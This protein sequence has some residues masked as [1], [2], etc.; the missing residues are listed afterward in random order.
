MKPEL[1][2][3]LCLI[4]FCV[5]VLI[6]CLAKKSNA[7]I[8]ISKD[9]IYIGPKDVCTA[10]LEVSLPSWDDAVANDTF[11][12]LDDTASYDIAFTFDDAE[13]IFTSKDGLLDIIYDPNKTTESAKVFIQCLRKLK[14]NF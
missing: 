12:T 2:I 4:A 13:I 1:G 3:V 14:A 10:D 11:L 7:E 5:G 9:A 6:F 8:E